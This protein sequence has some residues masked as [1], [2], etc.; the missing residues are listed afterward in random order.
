[1]K[2]IGIDTAS[3]KRQQTIVVLDENFRVS[4]RLE[5]PSE[6]DH[7]KDLAQ[8][9]YNEYGE[10]SII[11]IDAPRHFSKGPK[12]GRECERKLRRRYFPEVNPQW[13]PTAENFEKKA[14]PWHEWL[15]VGF[16]FFEAFGNNKSNVIE[17][18]PAASYVLL[19]KSD[20]SI[21]LPVCRI[22]KR[23]RE[24]ILDATIAAITGYYYNK[25]NEHHE[26]VGNDEEGQIV[27]PK[28]N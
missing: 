28:V 14:L 10:D 3:F 6:K 15:K 22:D 26:S 16:Y 9:I 11:A 18:F 20:I 5:N 12:N 25:G 8:D 1:V 4:V 13:A 7:I 2:Y 17:V 24:D 23:Y 27:I 19:K 21:Q